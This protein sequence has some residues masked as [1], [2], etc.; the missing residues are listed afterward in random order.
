MQERE[1]K[2]EE[3]RPREIL[4]ERRARTAHLKRNTGVLEGRE[5][6][7]KGVGRMGVLSSTITMGMEVRRSRQR[8][9]KS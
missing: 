1:G 6:Y 4:R 8:D 9:G 5:R 7:T 3:A 2:R